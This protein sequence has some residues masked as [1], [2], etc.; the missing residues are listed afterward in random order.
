MRLT[1]HIREAFVRAAMDDVPYVDY[2]EQAKAI[3]EKAIL[4]AMPASVK[5]L[6]KDNEAEPWINMSWV[7]M[8]RRFGNFSGYIPRGHNDGFQSL[9]PAAWIKIN[10]LHELNEKQLNVRTQLRIKLEGCAESVTTRKA[11][12]DL[13]PEFEKYLPADER[14]AIKTLPAV[15]NVIAD[16][17]G[18]GWPKGNTA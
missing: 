16:F 4:E 10:E 12:A 5:K 3:A 11:L 9:C 18:A 7:C 13:L 8:P 17:V 1:K 6:L 14:A 2:E 15:A